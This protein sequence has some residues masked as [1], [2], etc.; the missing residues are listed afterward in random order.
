MLTRGIVVPNYPRK[1]LA[2]LLA[3]ATIA[4]DVEVIL[5]PPRIF[6]Y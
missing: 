1:Q 2:A 3:A 5:T 4:L 6:H